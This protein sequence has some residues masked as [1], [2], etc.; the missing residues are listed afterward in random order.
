MLFTQNPRCAHGIPENKGPER[1]FSNTGLSLRRFIH[2]VYH[3]L[4]KRIMLWVTEKLKI[5]TSACSYPA[6]FKSFVIWYQLD[7]IDYGLLSN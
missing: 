1:D 3:F 4:S 5:Q 7:M 6:D 2:H